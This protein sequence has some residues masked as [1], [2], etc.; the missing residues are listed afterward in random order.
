MNAQMSAVTSSMSG[1]WI[2]MGARQPRHRP[3][4]TSHET[5][6]TLSYHRS[7][8]PHLGQCDGGRTTDSFGSAPQRRMHTLRKL[9]ITAPNNAAMTMNSGCSSVTHD[10]V[11]KDAGG[12]R[13]VERLDGRGQ[14][15]RDSARGDG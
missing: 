6:G 1:Y 12:D 5:I 7:P 13:H 8:I 9:P 3:R 2:E 15:N 11:Q 4:S 14:R 10:L